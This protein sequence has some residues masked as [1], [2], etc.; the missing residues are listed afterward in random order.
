MIRA[1]SGFPSGRELELWANEA[2]IWPWRINELELK[3]TPMTSLSGDISRRYMN[4]EDN[5]VAAF[6]PP[7]CGELG[8]EQE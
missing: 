5:A 8:Y 4:L 7:W 1:I 3:V 6:W 2:N